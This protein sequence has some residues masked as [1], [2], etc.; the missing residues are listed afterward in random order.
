MKFC[1]SHRSLW[2][3][4][5]AAAALVAA[6]TTNVTSTP[7]LSPG[8]ADVGAGDSDSGNES[9]S[10]PRDTYPFDPGEKITA[11]A[12]EWSWV[13]FDDSACANGKP[14]GI[15]INRGSSDKLVIYLEGGGACWDYSTCYSFKTATNIESGFDKTAF[16]ARMTGANLK[17]SHMDRESATNPFKDASFVYVP[18]CTGDVHSGS[19]E[20]NYDGSVTKHVGRKNLEAFLKRIVPTFDTVSRVVLTGSSAG[21]FGAAVNFWR[22]SHAFGT[23]VRVDLIDDSGPPFPSDKM[24]YIASWKTAWDLDSALPP[25]CD[26]CKDDLTTTIGYYSKQYPQSRL[27]LLS[28]NKDTVIRGFF[29]LDENAF[30]STL[31]SVVT[32]TF[33]STPNARAFVVNGDKHTMLGALSTATGSESVGAW[34]TRMQDDSATWSTTKP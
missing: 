10:L 12:G 13:P 24:K 1:H 7:D 16:E 6:C 25:G 19:K 22:V 2:L 27:A 8:R 3:T 18:Y 29:D 32:D 30:S 4:P 14:T 28:Y 15:G 9:E 26:S 17:G 23:K 5:F 31:T 21:G 34:I 33:D 20:S 11:P